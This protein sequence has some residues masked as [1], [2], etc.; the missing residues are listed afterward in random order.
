[1]EIKNFWIRTNKGNVQI[2]KGYCFSLKANIRSKKFDLNLVGSWPNFPKN[3]VRDYNISLTEAKII[4]LMNEAESFQVNQSRDDKE[5]YLQIETND[6][7]I[8]V[9]FQDGEKSPSKEVQ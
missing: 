4:D 5:T 2:R 3:G 8:Y 1:M 9:Y 6:Y 7:T